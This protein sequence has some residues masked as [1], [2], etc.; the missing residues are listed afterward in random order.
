MPPGGRPPRARCTTCRRPR[1]HR[2]GP[3]RNANATGAHTNWSAHRRSDGTRHTPPRCHRS[4]SA[5]SSHREWRLPWPGCTDRAHWSSRYSTAQAGPHTTARSCRRSTAVATPAGL[6]RGCRARSPPGSRH[7][8]SETPSGTTAWHHCRHGRTPRSRR[9]SYAS[10]ST[11]S[12]RRRRARCRG[13]QRYGTPGGRTV[14]STGR[15]GCRTI[16][17]SARCT[18][19]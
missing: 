19:R 3:P 14:R 5:R 17:A 12:A 2:P 11:S 7:A 9:G 18:R 10:T 8:G 6:P 1:A 15:A 16:R 4:P 13:R